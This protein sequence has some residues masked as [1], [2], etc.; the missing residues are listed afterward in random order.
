MHVVDFRAA[1]EERETD[2]PEG[3]EAGAEDAEGV[4]VCAAGED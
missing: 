4:D 3:L 2:V 1:E